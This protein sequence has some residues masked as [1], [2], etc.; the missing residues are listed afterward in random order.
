MNIRWSLTNSTCLWMWIF[1]PKPC[2][3]QKSSSRSRQLSMDHSLNWAIDPLV[4]VEKIPEIEINNLTVLLY[5]LWVGGLI[6]FVHGYVL[7]NIKVIVVISNS[8]FPSLSTGWFQSVPVRS[9]CFQLVLFRID[10]LLMINN[11]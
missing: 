1:R 8:I 7:I 3:V 4:I 11:Q 2:L 6:F 5:C 10:Y 9:S